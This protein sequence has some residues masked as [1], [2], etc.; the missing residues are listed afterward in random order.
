L[1]DEFE[2]AHSNVHKN[3][4]TAWN[5]GFITE[6]SDESHIST[7]AAIFVLTTNAATEALATI[8][9]AHAHSPDDMRRSA[10]AALR[11]AGFAPEVLS[12][13]DRIFIFNSLEGLDVAR[14]AA[15]EIE[16]MIKGYGLSVDE[17]GIDPQILLDLM[18]RQKKLGNSASSRDLVRAIE[19]SVADSLIVAKQRGAQSVSL[20]DELGRVTAR[21]VT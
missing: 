12:R 18:A 11:S 5:D 16:R 4:L 6:A 20:V 3:F 7:T 13:I 8:K 9:R 17:R 2:K 10:D 15:L 21:V 1:L 19:E 14:V